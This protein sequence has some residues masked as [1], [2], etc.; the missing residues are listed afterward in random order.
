MDGWQK[1]TLTLR[2]IDA[3]T[4]PVW[5]CVQIGWKGWKGIVLWRTSETMVLT[6]DLFR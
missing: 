2:K 3:D 6:V 1:T 5:T 4:E